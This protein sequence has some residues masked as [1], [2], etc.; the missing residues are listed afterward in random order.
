MAK[1]IHSHLKK[2]I[3]HALFFHL[4]GDDFAIIAPCK[5]EDTIFKQMNVVRAA[6]SKTPLEIPYKKKKKKRIKLSITGGLSCLAT[7]TRFN[8]WKKSC[9]KALAQGKKEGKNRIVRVSQSTIA[10]N[11][12]SKEL[13]ANLKSFISEAGDNEYLLGMIDRLVKHGASLDYIDPT[14]H[15]A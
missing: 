1:N 13:Y 6:I 4:F 8:Q 9:E 10:S 11:K 15:K 5:D 2:N 7:G 14:D 12:W 3:P